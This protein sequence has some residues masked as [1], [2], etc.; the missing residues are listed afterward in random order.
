MNDFAFALII[1]IGATLGLVWVV[2]RAEPKMVSTVLN[3]GLASLMGAYLGSRLAYIA[4]NAT[5]FRSYPE[6]LWLL[7]VGGFA[8]PGALAGGVLGLL[9]FAL[10]AG[11]PLGKLADGLLPLM[12]TV[13]V[14][15]WLACWL[16]GCA[17][18]APIETWWGLLAR[19]EWGVFTRR[20]P[21]QAMGALLSLGIFWLIDQLPLE[22]FPPGLGFLLGILGISLVN[23]FMSLVR[24]DPAPSLSGLR[25]DAWIALL[26]GGLTLILLIA[27][28]ISGKNKNK[29][30]TDMKV[31]PPG[32]S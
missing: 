18:G 4:V 11:Q 5:Y 27:V 23:F 25:Y 30:Q 21:V 17:Y 26:F 20:W 24:I 12:V 19:D 28:M 2:Y 7:P 31:K 29:I 1:G 32:T 22:R 15:G 9:I 10:V 14:S 6:D 16:V 3:A 13:T 8:W